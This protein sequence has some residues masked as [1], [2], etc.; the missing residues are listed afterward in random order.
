MQS[1]RLAPSAGRLLLAMV[2]NRNDMRM[3]KIWKDDGM[4]A[5]TEWSFVF[6]LRV[7]FI[8]TKGDVNRLLGEQ[9]KALHRTI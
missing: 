2:L 3:Q 5:K 8:V 7:I 6:Y 1:G 9:V 4:M